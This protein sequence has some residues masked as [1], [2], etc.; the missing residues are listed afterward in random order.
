MGTLMD[1]ALN[2]NLTKITE[3]LVT[4][5][6]QLVLVRSAY[7]ISNIIK[8]INLY[9]LNPLYVQLIHLNFVIICSE[10][11]LLQYL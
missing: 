2:T 3:S 7:C 9:F 6:Y 10:T 1:F 4:T 11:G 5:L 8:I